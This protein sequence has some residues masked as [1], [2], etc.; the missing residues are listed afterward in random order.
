MCAVIVSF[1]DGER[2]MEG[3]DTSRKRDS[4]SSD[5]YRKSEDASNSQEEENAVRCLFVLKLWILK[6]T[7]YR[8]YKDMHS[9]VLNVH[10]KS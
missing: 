3:T 4:R 5:K 2:P 7:K 10:F 1:T 9:I 6:K 8:A